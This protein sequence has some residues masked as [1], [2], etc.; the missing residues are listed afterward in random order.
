MRRW[1]VLLIWGLVG[2]ASLLLVPFEVFLP[3]PGSSASVRVLALINPAILT[4]IAV[5]AGELTARRVGLRAPLVEA[6]LASKALSGILRNQIAPA[7]VVGA[8]VAVVLIGY[9][10]TIGA[11]LIANAGSQARIASFDM[12][13]ASKLLYGGVTEEIPTR[14]GLVSVFAWVGWRLAGRPD[15]LPNVVVAL[16]VIGAA[17]LFAAG[18]LP[19]LSLIA[20]H[21][22]PR[23]VTTVLAANTLPGILFGAL[24]VRR[25]L[26]AAMMA[27]ASAHILATICL[28]ALN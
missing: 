8:T 4:I 6:W 2:V 19:L 16:A 15:R 25:G 22:S 13:L 3:M 12:P 23:V 18:H 20:P 14:W 11:R 27:H 24:F 17:V 5:F 10:L 9:N 7:L 26:E 28:I 21:A 1:Q